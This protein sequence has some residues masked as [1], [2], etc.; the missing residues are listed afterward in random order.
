[1]SQYDPK[2]KNKIKASSYITSIQIQEVL[3]FA[4]NRKGIES[5]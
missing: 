1:M 5:S 3:N 2:R 4:H